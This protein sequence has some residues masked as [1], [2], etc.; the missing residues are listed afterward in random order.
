MKIDLTTHTH[1]PTPT[2]TRPQQVL[3][4][5][6]TVVLL[7]MG[8]LIGVLITFVAGVHVNNGPERGANIFVN[9]ISTWVNISP[10]A[11]IFAILPILIFEA[12]FSANLFLFYKALPA[13]LIMAI[14]VVV[15]NSLTV[16]FVCAKALHY[17]DGWDFA[18][19][20]LLGSILSPTD[21][22]APMAILKELGAPES[23]QLIVEGESLLNDGSALVLFTLA[24]RMVLSSTI[25]TGLEAVQAVARLSLIGPIIGL[26]LGALASYVRAH[27]PGR[28][29]TP[30]AVSL[31]ENHAGLPSWLGLRVP[32][33]TSNTPTHAHTRP[34]SL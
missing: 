11:I 17:G 19:A 20:F 28:L 31:A 18:T 6:Y 9:S 1:K 4:I 26:A 13:V 24:R 27:T 22:V 15:L 34:P 14:P 32:I 5:P 8:L 3:P 7:I 29:S 33:P 21:T 10:E 23:L 2:H 16:A 12:S 25:P 30:P